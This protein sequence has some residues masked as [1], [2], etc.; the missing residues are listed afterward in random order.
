MWIWVAAAQRWPRWKRSDG[1]DLLR[2]RV[3]K[4]LSMKPEEANIQFKS[5]FSKVPDHF[6]TNTKLCRPQSKFEQH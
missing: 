6:E 4:T 2:G 1:N 5:S 3:V